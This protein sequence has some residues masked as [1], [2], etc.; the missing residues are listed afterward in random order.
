MNCPLN[1]SSVILLCLI[2]WLYF[3]FGLSCL[4]TMLYCWDILHNLS[5]VHPA[6]PASV[7]TESYAAFKPLCNT[8]ANLNTYL[9]YYILEVIFIQCLFYKFVFPRYLKESLL[10]DNSISVLLWLSCGQW[11]ALVLCRQALDCS[12]WACCPSTPYH[13]SIDLLLHL[14]YVLFVAFSHH[15]LSMLLSTFP[16]LLFHCQMLSS[17]LHLAYLSTKVFIYIPVHSM[18]VYD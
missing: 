3:G 7:Q 12:L 5:H 4:R 6:L 10:C 1:C 14:P 2:I 15:W 9:F 13:R 17:F 8:C 18:Y 11:S 16:L